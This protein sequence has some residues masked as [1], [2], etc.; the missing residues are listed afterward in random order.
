MCVDVERNVTSIYEKV[1]G[2]QRRVRSLVFGKPRKATKAFPERS[3]AACA[4]RAVALILARF[5]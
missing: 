1:S 4:L 3:E 5:P 2:A